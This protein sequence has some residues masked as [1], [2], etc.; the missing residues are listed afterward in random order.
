ME[1]WIQMRDLINLIFVSILVLAILF[2]VYKQD[3]ND[4]TMDPEFFLLLYASLI[5]GLLLLSSLE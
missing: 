2:G 1:E 3:F 5:I 4:R